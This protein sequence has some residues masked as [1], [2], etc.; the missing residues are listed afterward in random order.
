MKHKDESLRACPVC[1]GRFV[2]EYSTQVYCC[3]LCRDK[4]GALNRSDMVDM[5]K[6]HSET[7]DM[8]IR[9]WGRNYGEGQK[10]LT[11]QKVGKVDVEGIMKELER[12]EKQQNE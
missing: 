9:A 5:S 12:K 10:V 2:P 11:L 6:Y 7:L 4:R 3:R 8:K 1:G